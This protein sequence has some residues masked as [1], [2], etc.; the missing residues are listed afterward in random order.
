MEQKVIATL[1]FFDCK[2]CEWGYIHTRNSE[3]AVLES[4]ICKNC[5]DKGYYYQYVDV[6]ESKE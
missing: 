1:K 6:K 4:E 2:E 5:N 3:S